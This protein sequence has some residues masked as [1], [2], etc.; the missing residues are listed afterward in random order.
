MKSEADPFKILF[1]TLFALSAFASNS[2]FCRLALFEK[3]IDAA[4]FTAIRLISGAATLVA[5]SSLSKKKTFPRNVRWPSAAMLFLYAAAFSF[6]YIRLTAGTG[7]LVLFGTVQTTMLV[8][9]LRS[10]EQPH[11]GEWGG[12]LLALTGLI[13]LASPGLAAPSPIGFVSMVIAGI[14][15]GLYSLLGRRSIDPLADTTGNFLYSAPFALMLPLLVF[16]RIH[17]TATGVSLAVVSGALASGIG[18]VAWYAALR[19]LTATRAATVQLTVP[20]LAGIAGVVWLSE[21]VSARLILS[22]MMILG[23]VGLAVY[24]GRD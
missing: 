7:A 9:A 13:Y 24:T 11:M 3:S 2:I 17:L 18:Y 15:W 10:G 22:S 4:S 19:G 8:S 6:A 1:Y 14:S 16:D 12:L 20:V 23:G 21:H 5:V